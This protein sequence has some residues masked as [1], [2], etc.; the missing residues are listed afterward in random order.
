VVATLLG[1]A[2]FLAWGLSNTS[3]E[4]AAE[5]SSPYNMCTHS[6]Q[7][8]HEISAPASWP[9]TRAAHVVSWYSGIVTST[10]YTKS[11]WWDP[12]WDYYATTSKAC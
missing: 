4:D 11:G 9:G 10:Y 5:A 3:H 6:A 7:G 2:M 12:T 8:I 1:I